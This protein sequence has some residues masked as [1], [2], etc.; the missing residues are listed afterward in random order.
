MRVGKNLNIKIGNMKL[1]YG[2][3]AEIS[4]RI[5]DKQAERARFNRA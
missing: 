4:I 2:F 1:F 3:Y 5:A